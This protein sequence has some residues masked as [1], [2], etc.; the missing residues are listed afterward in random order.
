MQ[1]NQI[2]R[3]AAAEVITITTLRPGDVYSRLEKQSYG[4]RYYIRLGIVQTVHSNGDDTAFTAVE[5][6]SLDYTMELKVFGSGSD[7]S[8]FTATTEEIRA[9]LGEAQ[10]RITREVRD[11]EQ[12]LSKAKDRR[13]A[14]D[15]VVDGATEIRNPQT[16][17]FRGL[18][19]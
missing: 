9:V 3:P 12:A 17:I 13:A 10:D 4:D 15:R 8:L 18:D 19:A 14:I 11:A 5:V 16:A 7:L 2:I 6:D 1:V